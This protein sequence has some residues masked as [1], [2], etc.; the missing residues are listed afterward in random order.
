MT[1]EEALV[2]IGRR[3]V[4]R[5]RRPLNDDDRWEEDMLDD[6]L[7]GYRGFVRMQLR[8]TEN[9]RESERLRYILAALG[10]IEEGR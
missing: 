9:A 10:D 4:L 2:A 5:A 3:A 6:L 8:T 1:S 7:I